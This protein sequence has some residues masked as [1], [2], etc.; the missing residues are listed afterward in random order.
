MKTRSK[1]YKRRSIGCGCLVFLIIGG[2]AFSLALKNRAA[3]LSGIGMSIVSRMD[4]SQGIG[5]SLSNYFMRVQTIE[6]EEITV[7]SPPTYT[8]ALTN[9]IDLRS[10]PAYLQGRESITLSSAV[11]EDITELYVDLGMAVTQGQVLAV[12][13][14]TYTRITLRNTEASLKEAYISYSN[15]AINVRNNRILFEKSIIGDEMLRTFTVAYERARSTYEKAEA[16]RDEAAARVRDCSVKAP[17]AGKISAQYVEKGERVLVNQNLFTLVVDE[18]L[19][20]IFFV[21]DRVVS[22][23]AEDDCV[24]FTVDSIDTGM[25]TAHVARIGADVEPDAHLYRI[26]A[27]FSA[28]NSHVK[29]GMF[30]RVSMP[31]RAFRNRVFIPA[32]AI[33]YLESGAVVTVYTPEKLYDVQVKTGVNVDEWTEISSGLTPGMKV[34]LQ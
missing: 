24:P 10:F 8:V 9:I 15:A 7:P 25:L 5:R 29:P 21:E 17:C 28:T 13:D 33:T 18:E 20:L 3:T 32:Y 2:I 22:T 1:K 19:E 26:E 4:T 31:V 30:A 27:V 12:I 11:Q 16:A 34:L 14:D 23:I 6:E